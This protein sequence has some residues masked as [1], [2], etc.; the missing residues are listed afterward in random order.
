MV[1]MFYTTI[2]TNQDYE[3][4][5]YDYEESETTPEYIMLVNAFQKIWK[6]TPKDSHTLV[7]ESMIKA[8]M[9][10]RQFLCTHSKENTLLRKS[11]NN[12]KMVFTIQ[13]HNIK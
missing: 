6:Y 9:Y 5:A 13:Q 7:E 2:S 11:I 1:Y 10:V 4:K 12:S 3:Q 8:N